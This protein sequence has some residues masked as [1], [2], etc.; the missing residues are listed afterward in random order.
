M[1]II[2]NFE[3]IK[4]EQLN[5]HNRLISIVDINEYNYA[6]KRG[7]R[8]MLAE[9]GTQ[10]GRVTIDRKLQ[11]GQ[12][13]YKMILLLYQ[14]GS[15]THSKISFDELKNIKVVISHIGLLLSLSPFQIK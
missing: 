2:E 8:M 13:E 5:Y 7:Y 12:K 11:A 3:K 1:L 14:P 9:G 6:S 4:N 15:V 10:I